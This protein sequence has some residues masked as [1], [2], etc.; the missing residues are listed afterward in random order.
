MLL[1]EPQEP[2]PQE[3]VLGVGSGVARI[4]K[5]WEREHI[6]MLQGG[7]EANDISC[8]IIANR[9]RSDGANITLVCTC[10]HLGRKISW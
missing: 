1:W 9:Y 6:L 7:L 2:G 8:Q 5:D 4:G 3:V 10:Q